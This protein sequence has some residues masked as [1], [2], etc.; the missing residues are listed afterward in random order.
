MKPWRSELGSGPHAL[1]LG[2]TQGARFVTANAALLVGC[3]VGA[4]AGGAPADRSQS[5]GQ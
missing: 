4:T 5:G 2:T 3:V 1:P